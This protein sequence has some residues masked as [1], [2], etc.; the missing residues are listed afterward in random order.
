MPARPSTDPAY[1]PLYTTARLL[2]RSTVG[3]HR[4]SSVFIAGIATPSPMP[5]HARTSRSTG[6]PACAAT[7][8]SAVASDHHATPK[9]STRLPPKRS[10]HTPP[11]I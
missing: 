1:I 9:P 6:R 11:A 8:V 3:T 2:L 7:G 5:M 10:D 4:L